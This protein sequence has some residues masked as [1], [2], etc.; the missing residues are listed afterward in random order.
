MPIAIRVRDERFRDIAQLQDVEDT[1]PGEPRVLLESHLP[2]GRADRYPL[3]AHIDPVGDTCFNRG[4]TVVLM[5]ELR[6]WADETGNADVRAICGA[7]T[8]LVATHMRRPHTYLW[9][10]G[11]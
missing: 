11:D 10:L 8:V 9:L 7:L 2:L 5:S 3:L 6:R 1:L 4:Q